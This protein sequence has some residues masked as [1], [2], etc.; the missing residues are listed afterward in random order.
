MNVILNN[1][2]EKE[3]FKKDVLKKEVFKNDFKTSKDLKKINYWYKTFIDCHSIFCKLITT[4]VKEEMIREDIYYP[5]EK[6]YEII[7]AL[8]N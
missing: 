4:F 3:L 1:I 6:D 8:Q 5:Q 2:L 7:Y